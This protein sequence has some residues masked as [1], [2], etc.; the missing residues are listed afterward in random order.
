MSKL[1]FIAGLLVSTQVVSTQ[2]FAFDLGG[3]VDRVSDNFNHKAEKLVEETNRDAEKLIEETANEATDELLGVDE[4]EG[5][6]ATTTSRRGESRASATRVSSM[7][8]KRDS[9]RELKELKDEG[10]ISESEY[11]EGRKKILA[12]P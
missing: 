9:L 5:A 10:L 1:T 11:A 3:I 8:S 7:P 2:A 6:T 12:R 4:S